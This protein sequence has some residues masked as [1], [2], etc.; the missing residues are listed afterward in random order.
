MCRKGA[1]S[2][3][4]DSIDIESWF[5]TSAIL[6]LQDD[7]EDI[8]MVHE[9][10]HDVVAGMAREND[11]ARSGAVNET[12]M[13]NELIYGSYPVLR[14]VGETN[15]KGFAEQIVNILHRKKIYLS[16]FWERVKKFK[17]CETVLAQEAQ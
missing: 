15:E 12:S 5:G 11:I 2:Q 8:E 14:T 7:R 9:T 16:R 17:A 13:Q 3:I 4:T 6:V 1:S 10:E